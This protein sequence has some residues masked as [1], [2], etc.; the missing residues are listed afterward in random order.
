MKTT[1]C[2]KAISKNNRAQLDCVPRLAR[3]FTIIEILIVLSLMALLS[4]VVIYQ[5]R[6]PNLDKKRVIQWVQQAVMEARIQAREK[7]QRV[8]LIYDSLTD[9]LT[10]NDSKGAEIQ[11][12]KMLTPASPPEK[13]VFEFRKPLD[14]KNSINGKAAYQDNN[15]NAEILRFGPQ[16]EAP[17]TRIRII[18]PTKIETFY[19]DA[20]SDT[21]YQS[22]PF[23]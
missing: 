15:A 5:M 17:Y 22:N 14:M 6:P 12:W 13:M 10:L 18:Y 2:C 4:G 8:H 20:F 1:E 19:L 23:G 3:G 21:L 11:S 16:G 9:T 7:N